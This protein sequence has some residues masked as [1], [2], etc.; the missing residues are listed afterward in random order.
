LGSKIAHR[1]VNGERMS[2]GTGDGRGWQ[3]RAGFL[4]A[5]VGGTALLAAGCGASASSAAGASK[6]HQQAL[7]FVRCMRTSGE[8]TFPGPA[9]NGTIST[10]QVNIS[11]PGYYA[12]FNACGQL[13][14]NGVQVQNSAAQQQE[15]LTQF[16]KFSACMRSHGI[17]RFPDPTDL[18]GNVGIHG[19]GGMGRG[20]P[21]LKA[22][23][24]ACRSLEPGSPS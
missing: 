13:L 1:T 17:P 14:R 24:R 3:W 11:S 4:A 5:V 19:T 15:L 20:S 6:T 10:S 18:Q 12:A 9:S 23:G 7:A 21:V 22:A 16:L 2:Y 8:P